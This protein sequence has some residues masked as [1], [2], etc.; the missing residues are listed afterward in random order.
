M[1]RQYGA[2]LE[3]IERLSKVA[4]LNKERPSQAL[5]KL[6]A[7]ACR[8]VGN[9]NEEAIACYSEV[10]R[11]AP[12]D[13]SAYYGRGLC[14]LQAN[15]PHAAVAEFEKVA[16]LADPAPAANTLARM[17]EA[18]YRTRRFAEAAAWA[19][20]A[21]KAVEAEKVTG[22]AELGADAAVERGTAMDAELEGLVWRGLSALKLDGSAQ[23]AGRCRTDFVR[24]L[25]LDPDFCARRLANSLREIDTDADGDL[26]AEEWKIAAESGSAAAETVEQLEAMF[27]EAADVAE[28]RAR[29]LQAADKDGDGLVDDPTELLVVLSRI[30]EANGLSAGMAEAADI[31]G[32][33][34]SL[35]TDGSGTLDVG[36]VKAMFVMLGQYA[37]VNS[38]EKLAATFAMLDADGGGEI[39]FDEFQAW[40][41]TTPSA[42]DG[43]RRLV[44]AR[45]TRLRLVAEQPDTLIERSG[46]PAA[47]LLADA[48]EDMRTVCELDPTGDGRMA[49][50]VSVGRLMRLCGELSEARVLS[51][52]VV[53][54]VAEGEE[55]I[56]KALAVV[57]HLDADAQLTRALLLWRLLKAEQALNAFDLAAAAGMPLE[58]S[59]P[60]AC[61]RAATAAAQLSL[62]GEGDGGAVALVLPPSAQKSG[63]DEALSL[64]GTVTEAVRFAQSESADPG[65]RPE[66]HLHM[67]LLLLVQDLGPKQ[68]EI[69]AGSALVSDEAADAEAAAVEAAAAA[70]AWHL[71]RAGSIC[72]SPFVARA[73][74]GPIMLHC[75]LEVVAPAAGGFNLEYTVGDK[76][77]TQPEIP[78]LQYLLLSAMYKNSASVAGRT[79]LGLPQ[80]GKFRAKWC[81]IPFV[82]AAL[83]V[84]ADKKAAAEK[85]N[86][87]TKTKG[88]GKK[89]K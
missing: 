71:R 85:A 9:R 38:E 24:V 34:R 7:D 17:A 70:A 55:A 74:S 10:L 37:L 59:V 46:K 88:K 21:L 89:K 53:A 60:L 77:K 26:S 25:S 67:G 52:E 32:V 84:E 69:T 64:R 14:E 73:V 13:I 15:R 78:S 63:G 27:P 31:D 48:K 28:A 11:A 61:C 83:K 56:D 81:A 5:I 8:G 76:K 45:T 39:D 68:P 2:A 3:L 72:S 33:W 44:W 79:A 4:A 30:V 6:R 43:V 58:G 35:D 29:L 40:W 42:T 1:D 49:A 82:A 50:K 47:A 18:M 87:K 22:G 86:A 75:V 36:E 66:D 54:E 20:R 80:L 23:T 16:K 62:D 12:F 51:E 57:V 41:A 65:L 19:E